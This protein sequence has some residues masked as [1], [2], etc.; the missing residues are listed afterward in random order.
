[1]VRRIWG[2]QVGQMMHFP[3]KE[4]YRIIYLIL[5]HRLC[6]ASYGSTEKPCSEKMLHS[7]LVLYKV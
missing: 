6:Q 5:V 3:Q 1:M 4:I 2:E 7:N